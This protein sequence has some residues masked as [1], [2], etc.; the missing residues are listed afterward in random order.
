MTYKGRL[1]NSV[2]WLT[3]DSSP[4]KPP[5][6]YVNVGDFFDGTLN[7]ENGDFEL[8]RAAFRETSSQPNYGTGLDVDLF[9]RVALPLT[10]NIFNES[11]KMKIQHPEDKPWPEWVRV[12]VYIKSR[13]DKTVAVYRILSVGTDTFKFYQVLSNGEELRDFQSSL[14]RNDYLLEFWGPVDFEPAPTCWD[15]LDQD[16]DGD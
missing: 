16:S 4:M 3:W 1:K 12:G 7:L 6:R 9:R 5:R 11:L 15:R 13:M 10:K 2:E 14:G 8:L